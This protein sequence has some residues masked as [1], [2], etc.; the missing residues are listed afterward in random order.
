[1][2]FFESYFRNWLFGF[3]NNVWPFSL[4][5]CFPGLPLLAL[6]PQQA[7]SFEIG[8]EPTIPLGQSAR[9]ALGFLEESPHF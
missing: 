1:V 3:G 2:A 6:S 7:R 9:R 4:R 8:I 5:L